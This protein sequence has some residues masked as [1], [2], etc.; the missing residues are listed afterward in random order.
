MNQ[1]VNDRAVLDGGVTSNGDLPKGGGNGRSSR[2]DLDKSNV[3]VTPAMQPEL[4]T[5]GIQGLIVRTCG[6]V[7]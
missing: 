3:G 6:W 2:I 1:N 7:R 4:V 5:G